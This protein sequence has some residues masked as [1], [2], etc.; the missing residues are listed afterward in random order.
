MHTQL[1]KWLGRDLDGAA[2]N[3]AQTLTSL[4][5]YQKERHPCV[6]P[7]QHLSALCACC[8]LYARR[9]YEVY[10]DY[11]L[12]NPFYEVEQVGP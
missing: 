4:F 6:P 9:V 2:E 5:A 3:G 8:L 10:T 7:P 12:K 1:H 11:V